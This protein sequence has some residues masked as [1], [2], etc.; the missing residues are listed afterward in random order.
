[1]NWLS[2]LLSQPEELEAIHVYLDERPHWVVPAVC[3]LPAFFSS[4]PALMP[5]GSMLYLENT[6]FA[7]DVELLMNRL[8]IKAR[9][10]IEPGTEWPVPKWFH[11][12]VTRSNMMQLTDISRQRPISDVADHLVG[13]LETIVVFEWYDLLET[14]IHVTGALERVKVHRF[15]SSLG[16]PFRFIEV[17]RGRRQNS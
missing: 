7:E 9:R 16:V 15:A 6:D 4:L 5:I 3:S 14:P 2:R 12:P 13:Y 8:S 10:K 17:G 11:I 1:M